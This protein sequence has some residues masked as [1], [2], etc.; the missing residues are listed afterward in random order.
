MFPVMEEENSDEPSP[1]QDK[2]ARAWDSKVN[3]RKQSDKRKTSGT[4]ASGLKGASTA[5]ASS[6]KQDDM[7]VHTKMTAEV[8]A[9]FDDQTKI[10]STARIEKYLYDCSK[11]Q[12]DV[13]ELLSLDESSSSRSQSEEGDFESH[14]PSMNT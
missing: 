8:M 14:D 9:L 2:P 4:E 7:Y 6:A 3:R 10:S 11:V 13:T 5:D 1:E 12:A